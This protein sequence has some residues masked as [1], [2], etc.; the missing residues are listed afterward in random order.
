MLIRHLL[1]L[2][3]RAVLRVLVHVDGAQLARVPQR[4]PLI[5]ATNHVNFL[6]VPL[7]FTLLSPRPI[8]VMVKAETMVHP[9]LGWWFTTLAGS[10]AISLRRGEADLDAVHR[11]LAALEAG[12]IVVVA[13]EGTRSGHGRLQRGLPGVAILALHSGAPVLPLAFHGGEQFWQNLKRL[14]RTDFII[15]VGQPF[16][17]DP[18]GQPVRR[19]ERLQMAA[20]IMYQLAALLPPPYRGL[21]ADLDTATETFLRFP[22]GSVSNLKSSQ[23]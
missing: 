3:M 19:E 4:G 15:R 9:L 16:H 11:A 5:L 18:G 6:E 13:P 14:R 1:M 20:E 21:Y 22:E 17:L 12:H 23:A 10:G 8:S 2:V 7:L